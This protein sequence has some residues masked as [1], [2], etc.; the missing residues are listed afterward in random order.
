MYASFSARDLNW[1]ADVSPAF[2]DVCAD[3]PGTGTAR[4]STQ[5]EYIQSLGDLKGTLFDVNI[6]RRRYSSDCLRRVLTDALHRLI[7]NHH[8]RSVKYEKCVT[9]APK[10]SQVS[11]L[12][13]HGMASGMATIGES[14]ATRLSHIIAFG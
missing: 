13:R 7:G 11:A 3:I 8:G 9:D 1:T 12:P 10:A 6:D 2:T 5:S 4:S 14:A